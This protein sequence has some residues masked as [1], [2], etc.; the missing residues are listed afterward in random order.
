V[1]HQTDPVLKHARREALII[2]MVWLAATTYSCVSCYLLGYRREGHMLGVPDIH[3]VFGMPSWVFW[4]IIAPW[5]ACAL[6]TFWFAG[7]YM[8]DDEL[9]KDHTPELESDIRER[10]LHE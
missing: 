1:S 5:G 9:G 10:G 6:F 3:P 7:F 2:G 4:G 8:A